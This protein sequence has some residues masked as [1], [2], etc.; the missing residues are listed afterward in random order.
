M[1]STTSKLQILIEAK[2]NSSGAI[3]S[4]ESDLK[5][6]DKAAGSIAGGLSG[7]A[8]AAGIAGV[9]ALGTA[10]AGAAV[11]MARGAAEAERLGTAFD[12]LASQAGESGDAMLAAMQTAAQGTISNT[13]LMASAN[14]AM[15]LGVADSAGEMAQLLEVASARGKAMGESTAQAFSDLVTGIGRMSPLAKLAA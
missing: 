11:D 9:A 10:A 1:A 2:N 13:E 6:L 15:L 8:G 7:L 5:G 14:R 12:T 4:V 3:K